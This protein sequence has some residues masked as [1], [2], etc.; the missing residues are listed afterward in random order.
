MTNNQDENTSEFKAF[1]L[2]DSTR[3]KLS[4]DNYSKCI[5]VY[6]RINKQLVNDYPNITGTGIRLKV[7][8][9]EVLDKP[10]I[11]IMVKK[12]LS[13]QKIKELG[14]KI[15][16]IEIEGVPTDVE[17]TGEIIAMQNASD[18]EVL[19]NP[20]GCILK[21]GYKINAAGGRGFSGT[22]GCFVK[23][24]A[25]GSIS[26]LSNHHV[27][28]KYGIGDRIIQNGE[29]IATVSKD[30]EYNNN[31][32]LVDAA[33]AKSRR[34]VDLQIPGIGIPHGIRQVPSVT[35]NL[36][37]KKTGQR[38]GLT[39]GKIATLG[40][41]CN[42]LIN[43]E[44]GPTPVL[45]RFDQL[46]EIEPAEGNNFFSDEGDSG[47]IVLDADRNVLGLL[48]AANPLND[49]TIPIK[50]S[51]VCTIENVLQMLNIELLTEDDW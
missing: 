3:R 15:L 25:D 42:K 40:L 10:S 17:E 22:L 19:Q 33:I 41:V 28:G 8:N 51:Y 43:V 37:V 29:Y 24:R 12:K 23:D 50:K 16:P 39:T 5:T 7:T 2:D 36:L 34:P 30:I 48:I 21:P 18:P 4:S 38:T 13:L 35:D 31:I 26:L 27:I 44:K 6:N 32:N 49:P 47:S 45:K 20:S 46:Y 14:E 11:L 1:K 9:G